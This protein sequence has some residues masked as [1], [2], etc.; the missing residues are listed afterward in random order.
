MKNYF[1]YVRVS[2][3]KQGEKGVSLQEQRD[4]ILRYAARNGFEIGAWFEEWQ[5]AAKVG[6]P[7]F[8]AMMTRLRSK[9]AEGV[10]IHKIDRSARNLKDWTAIEEICDQNIAV[11]FV[12]ES[13]DLATTGGRLAADVQAVVA[14]HYVRNLREEAKKGFYGRLK[15][16]VYPL[17]APIGYV[18]MGAG[19]PKEIDPIRG[20][21]VRRT[22][23]L[24]ASGKFTLVTL[25]DELHRIG[26]RNRHGGPVTVS[27]LS[28]LLNNPF[29]IGIIRI[30]STEESFPGGH[31]PLISKRLFDQVQ[32]V[33]AGR[34]PAREKAHDFTCRRLFRCKICGYS[35][36][37]SERKG[38]VYFRCQTRTCPTNSVREERMEEALLNRFGEIALSEKEREYANGRLVKIRQEWRGRRKSEEEVLRL[39][40][41]Q[42]QA[43]LGRLTDAFIDATI[44]K[45]LFEE[46][47]GALL[48][49]RRQIEDDLRELR[50]NPEAAIDRATEFLGLAGDPVFLYESAIP[51]EKR[52]LALRLTSDRVV[53]AGNVAVTLVPACRFIAKGLQ[54]T[55]GG[56]LRNEPRTKALDRI[57]DY[58]VEH[59]KTAPPEI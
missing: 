54:N 19:K 51:V 49:E 38:H 28:K 57:V 12:S 25:R 50:Q 35:M 27:G 47:K 5:T 55:N 26:L 22:F 11:H 2:T 52:R 16:G 53:H 36:I 9:E 40:L 21:L 32:E 24:Y 18:D 34:T 13:L 41:D 8:N 45:S 7:V 59:F 58:L 30:R 33:L 56:P 14:A 42:I 37:G 6:R 1:A 20:P 46:R 48:L 3:A 23:D 10:I 17:P 39:R 31:E 4:G 43:R 15:Q 44:E 29:Y